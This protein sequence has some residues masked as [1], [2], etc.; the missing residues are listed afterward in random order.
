MKIL[1]TGDSFSANNNG[2]PNMLD[3]DFDNRS[4]N[5]VGEYKIYKQ[6]QN[7]EN[8]EKII[9]CHTSPYRLHTPYHPIHHKKSERSENDFIF[10]DVEYHSKNNKEMNLVHKYIQK[11]YDFEYQKF[12]YNLIVEE[13]MKIPNTIHIT[14]H[15]RDDT[16]II[17]NNL[18]KIWESNTGQI[19]HM[20]DKGNQETAQTIKKLL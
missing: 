4:Q 15:N 12:V 16:N 3:V 11:F 17:P 5:G 9:V 6:L 2:W 14:F 10:A 20:N 8:Y 18:S 7:Y 13:I 1:I 19:N